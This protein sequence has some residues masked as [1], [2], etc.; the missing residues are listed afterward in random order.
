[1]RLAVFFAVLSIAG[2][3]QVREQFREHPVRT[4]VLVGGAAAVAA[5]AASH[6]NDQQGG[7]RIVTL[8]AS[9]NC[10][11]NPGSCH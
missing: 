11:S 7:V 10:S 4:V 6:G 3:A 9:P 8:P 1:M 2:C 5:I